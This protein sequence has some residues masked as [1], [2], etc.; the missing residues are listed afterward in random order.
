MDTFQFDVI[1]LRFWH[2]A[3]TITLPWWVFLYLRNRRRNGPIHRKLPYKWPL[4]L[5]IF[6]SQY[7]A[8]TRGSL[9]AYQA[10]YF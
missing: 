2:F 6:K 9:L 7:Y 10:D 4:A 3:V 5:D 8:L 1:S